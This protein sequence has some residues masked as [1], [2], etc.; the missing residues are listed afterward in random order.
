MIW[1]WWQ[2]WRGAPPC[3]LESV[4]INVKDDPTAALAGV[5][6]G[7]HGAWL[8][9]RRAA[10]LKAGEPPAPIDGDVFVHVTNV[11]F[12]QADRRVE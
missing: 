10:L 4:V 1:R 11:S 9:L 5:L 12:I 3:L 8:V 2:R 7:L 6:F